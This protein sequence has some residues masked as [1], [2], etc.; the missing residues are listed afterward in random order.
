MRLFKKKDRQEANQQPKW[1]LRNS[2]GS[3]YNSCHVPTLFKAT[4]V[5]R[6]LASVPPNTY[7]VCETPDGA[8]G[9]DIIGFYTEAPLKTSGITPDA[10]AADQSPVRASSLKAFGD[11]VKS[12]YSVATLKSIGDYAAFVLQMECGR[13]GYQSPVETER[14]TFQR[15]CYACG[16]VNTVQRGRI[17]VITQSGPVDI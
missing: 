12:Q 9:R 10:P 3:A 11:G 17:Q 14:G 4:E 2:N 16:T 5:L 7:Y 13:C 8:L 6:D 1:R 15:Q